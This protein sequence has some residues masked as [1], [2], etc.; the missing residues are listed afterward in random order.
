MIFIIIKSIL[1][2]SNSQRSFCDE[3]GNAACLNGARCVENWDDLEEGFD[4]VCEA[5]HGGQYCQHELVSYWIIN[6]SA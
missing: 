4:C 1:S 2:I 5:S 3:A 6:I